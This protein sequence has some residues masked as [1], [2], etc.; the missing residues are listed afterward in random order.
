M[1]AAVITSDTDHD[2]SKTANEFTQ[3]SHSARR[4]V[5]LVCP[6]L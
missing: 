2:P 3:F 1:L 6:E 5:H 4:A